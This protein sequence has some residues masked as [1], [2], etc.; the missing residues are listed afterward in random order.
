[1][2][3]YLGT[4]YQVAVIG[5]VLLFAILVGQQ[6]VLTKTK[7]KQGE[8]GD[9]KEAQQNNAAVTLRV[10]PRFVWTG[11]SVQAVVRINPDA[12][13]RL[14][15][16]SVDSPNYFRSS[17]VTLDGADSA[18]THFLPFHALPAGAY[19]VHAVLYG[20]QGERARSEEKFDVL[21]PVEDGPQAG[22]GSARGLPG[23]K[24]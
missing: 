16:I 15:R 13:N 23:P 24:R 22:I 4:S 6:S 8:S 17:D 5:C 9:L 7:S 1:M 20:T 11:R 18:R 3:R 2:L 21:S 12:D 19:A 14:L 10:T